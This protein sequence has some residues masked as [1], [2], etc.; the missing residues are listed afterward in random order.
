MK[1]LIVLLSLFGFAHID[2]SAVDKRYLQVNGTAFE[3]GQQQGQ[4]LGKDLAFLVNRKMELIYKTAELKEQWLSLA[5][6]SVDY[7]KEYTPR[8]Y[9]EILG[10]ST[11]V[12]LETVLLANTDYVMSM[13]VLEQNYSKKGAYPPISGHCSGFVGMSKNSFLLGQTNDLDLYEWYNGSLELVIHHIEAETGLESLMYTDPGWPMSMGMNSAGLVLL[14]QLIDDGYRSK[15][16]KGVPN[17][18]A[19]RE[20]L[21]FT[22]MDDAVDYLCSIP[23]SIPNNYILGQVKKDEFG[24]DRFEYVNLEQGVPSGCTR[25][26][27][28]NTARQQYLVHTNHILFDLEMLDRGDYFRNYTSSISDNTVV[29]YEALHERLAAAFDEGDFTL[30]R[31]KKVYSE[32]PLLRAEETAATMLF[33]PLELQMNI[34]FRGEDW[35]QFKLG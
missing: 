1:I 31:L 10:I 4:E 25:V 23:I 9:Q 14:W 27:A 17:Y 6:D 12:P 35:R 21:T 29:R 8:T 5:Y 2:A 34:R 30:D 20:A 7:L 19:Q 11:T 16:Y 33:E 22:D 15:G 13:F 26:S 18:A 28:I 3:R 24:K 32:P